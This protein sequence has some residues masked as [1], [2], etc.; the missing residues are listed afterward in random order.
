MSSGRFY[1]GDDGDQIGQIG[2]LLEGTGRYR[3]LWEDDVIKP[4]FGILAGVSKES[5]KE[6]IHYPTLSGRKYINGR[7]LI[8]K[9]KACIKDSK[10]LLAYWKDFTKAGGFPS[11]KNETDALLFCTESVTTEHDQNMEK[12][13]ETDEDEDDDKDPPVTQGSAPTQPLRNS[14]VV[15]SDNEDAEDEDEDNDSVEYVSKKKLVPPAL[16]TFMLLG[17]YGVACYGFEISAAF[18]VDTEAIEENAKTGMYNTKSMKE[19]KKAATDL[20][21]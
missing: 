15:D 2:A 13:N 1:H 11:G 18:S 14:R 10:V 21:R 19:E 3:V 20:V 5:V 12:E 8:A 17:P 16:V 6:F 7:Q 9:A 4:E